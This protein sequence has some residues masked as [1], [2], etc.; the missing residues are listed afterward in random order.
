MAEINENIELNFNVLNVR[1]E[2]GNDDQNEQI[3]DIHDV[4]A[5]NFKNAV[6]KSSR[7]LIAKLYASSTLNSRIRDY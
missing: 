1:E 7:T 5:F 2:I 3:E 4:T 6:F